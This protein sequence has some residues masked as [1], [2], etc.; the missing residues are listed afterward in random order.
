MNTMSTEFINIQIPLCICCLSIV[1]LENVL[2]IGYWNLY[3]FKRYHSDR[4]I[5][6]T[7]LLRLH[8]KTF[9]L[10]YTAHT[11]ASELCYGPSYV[12]STSDGYFL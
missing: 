10:D 3:T 9:I 2:R 1:C 8:L 12:V 7:L 6:A 11:T 4:E 5:T